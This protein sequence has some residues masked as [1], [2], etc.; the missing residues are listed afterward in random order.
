[1]SQKSSLKRSEVAR[2]NKNSQEYLK[3]KKHRYLQLRLHGFKAKREESLEAM[4]QNK[5]TI[6]QLIVCFNDNYLHDVIPFKIDRRK[7]AVGEWVDIRDSSDQWA[8][9]QIINEYT[10]YV[11]VHFN[12]Y[13]RQWDEWI[14]V[15][16][17]RIMPFR[18]FTV[19]SDTSPYLSPFPMQEPLIN[20]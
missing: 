5:H 2:I 19:Q 13:S 20:S 17:D 11:L 7:L 4:L 10:N 8:E 1:M 9:G 3:F 16:S 14:S 12:G 15:G 18:T 6:D